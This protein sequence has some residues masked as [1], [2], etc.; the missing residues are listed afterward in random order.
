MGLGIIL[1]L[2]HILVFI[3]MKGMLWKYKLPINNDTARVA[4]KWKMCFP[5]KFCLSLV[6]LS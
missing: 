2:S 1:Q 5:L 6:F 4:M 3:F